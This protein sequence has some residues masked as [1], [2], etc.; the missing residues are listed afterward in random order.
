M[1]TKV[2]ENSFNGKDFFVGIDSHKKSW[3]VTIMGR[4]YEHKTMSMD[5]ESEKLAQYL[6]SNFP[7]GTYHAVYEAGFSGFETCREL[8]NLGINCMVIHAAD[9]PTSHK[10]KVLKSDK[11]D[12]RKLSRCLRNNEVLGIHIP[13]RKTEADRALVRQRYRV[14]RDL[15]RTKGRLK[16]LLFQFQINIPI[17]FSDSQTRV[18]SK[19]YM[20]WLK[21]IDIQEPSIRQ[22]LDNYIRIGEE[23]RR[24]L[25]IINKQL[26][27]LSQSEE[28]KKNYSLLITIPGVGI[29]TAMTFLVQLAD[30][31]RFKNFDALCSYVGLIPRMHGSG[32]KI[33]TG[34]IIKRGHKPLKIMLIEA[35]W[36]AVRRD[37]ALMLNFEELTKRMQK[38]KAIIRIARKL[39]NRIRYVLIHQQPYELGVVA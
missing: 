16:S 21:N 13:N 2:N 29:M 3:K 19:R 15:T 39:L 27:N 1:R 31:T 10:E 18:W 11:A 12:S 23:Q 8:Q 22:V 20:D 37:P 14:M 33:R 26:R 35:S 9:V 17:E 32:D 5:P 6:K 36:E 28:Y 7:G 34:K 24:E 30:I 38:N 25:L 4:E